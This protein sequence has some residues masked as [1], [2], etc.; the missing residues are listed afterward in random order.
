VVIRVPFLSVGSAFFLLALQSA[1]FSDPKPS[2]PE[3]LQQALRQSATALLRQPAG[4]Q[5]G[6]AVIV[7]KAKVGYWLATNRHVVR[8]LSDV[9]VVTS[10]RKAS[11]AR[12][13]GTPAS[14][15]TPELDLAFV[16]LPANDQQ[17]IVAPP[18]SIDPKDDPIP[19]VIATGYPASDLKNLDGPSFSEREGLLLPLLTRPLQGG[20]QLAYTASISPGMSGGGIFQDGVLIGINGAHSDPLWAG[21]WSYLNGQ[22]VSTALDQKLDLLSLGIP[23]DAITRQL[24]RLVPPTDLTKLKPNEWCTLKVQALTGAKK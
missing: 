21:Q 24:D 8:G 23:A 12:V 20:F 9:C 6:S 5:L 19:F 13:I 14:S 10:D 16:W 18:K 17:L 1:A 11:T 22:P 15:R 7:A 2:S 3:A 4:E